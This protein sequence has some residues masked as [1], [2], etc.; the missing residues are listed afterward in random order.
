M[1]ERLLEGSGERRRKAAS[2][3]HGLKEL[4][5]AAAGAMRHRFDG[6]REQAR[7]NSARWLCGFMN[8]AAVS[9]MS[10]HPLSTDGCGS[11]CSA[12]GTVQMWEKCDGLPD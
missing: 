9:H 8:F 1:P 5:R 6:L 3:A 4:A 10:S 7:Q 12:V 2:S 11:S